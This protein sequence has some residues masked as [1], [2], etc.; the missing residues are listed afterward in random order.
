MNEE[1]NGSVEEKKNNKSTL[2]MKQEEKTEE[3]S[4]PDDKTEELKSNLAINEEKNNQIEMLNETF[5]Y[6]N[7]KPNPNQNRDLQDVVVKKK[8]NQMSPILILA[9]LAVIVMGIVALRNAFHE[10]HSDIE[11]TYNFVSA[12][13]NGVSL[14]KS[15]LVARGL[16]ANDVSLEIEDDMATVS[17]GNKVD[18]CELEV[19]GNDITLTKGKQELSGVVNKS[20]ETVTIEAEGVYLVFEKDGE[21]EI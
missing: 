13:L 8:N 5:F 19:D 15:Q 16:D 10:D 17:I 1:F 2:S 11:G 3:L 18:D 12:E 9:A 21:E 6:A 4:N 7:P 20:E 14:S